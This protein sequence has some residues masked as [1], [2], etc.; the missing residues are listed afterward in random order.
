MDEKLRNVNLKNM[1][2]LGLN[3]YDL[4]KKAIPP[5]SD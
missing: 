2:V 5:N 1:A 3:Y 4:F